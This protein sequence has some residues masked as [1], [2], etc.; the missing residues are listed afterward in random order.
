MGFR[1]CNQLDGWVDDGWPA[2]V[3]LE[4]VQFHVHIFLAARDISTLSLRP[5]HAAGLESVYSCN[6]HLD[7]GGR[8]YGLVPGRSVVRIGRITI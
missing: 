1:E 4:N 6:D 3:V 2:L 7:R 8:G 5:D